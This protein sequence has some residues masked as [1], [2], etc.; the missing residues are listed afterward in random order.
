MREAKPIEIFFSYTH[1]DE[2]LRDQ[3]EVHLASLKR[4]K[5]IVCWHD[6]HIRAGLTWK[7]QINTHLNTADII[8]F[9]VSPD[10][11]NSDYCNRIEVG[12]ALERYEEGD[13][14]IVPVILRRSDWKEEALA[15]FQALPCNARPVVEWPDI[16]EAFYDV[17]K[18]LKEI[19]VE[20]ENEQ[21][22]TRFGRTASVHPSPEKS[23]N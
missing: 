15:E 18:G 11:L 3:L 12:R 4:S 22:V 5:R 8:I 21:A 14:C 7:T 20:M 1:A 23:G 2:R 9:L 13:V 19:V 6:R 16:D 17:A 10:F